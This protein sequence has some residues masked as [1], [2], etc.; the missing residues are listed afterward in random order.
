M[1]KVKYDGHRENGDGSC[2]VSFRLPSRK[3][4]WSVDM[5]ADYKSN[6]VLTWIKNEGIEDFLTEKYYNDIKYDKSNNIKRRIGITLHHFTFY[7]N[8]F[9]GDI[10]IYRSTFGNDNYS[11]GLIKNIEDLFDFYNEKTINQIKEKIESRYKIKVKSVKLVKEDLSG[12]SINFG[13]L[14]QYKREEKLKK[15]LDN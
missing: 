9:D 4:K 3:A 11:W 2:G 10:E 6:C 8:S 7:F 13:N 15:L 14:C 1:K 5:P 12:G